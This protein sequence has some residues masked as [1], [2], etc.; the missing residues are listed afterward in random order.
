[1][2]VEITKIGERGQV[3]IPQSCRE[4]MGIQKG[5]KFIVLERGDMI[6]LK[7]LKSPTEEDID[8]MFDKERNWNN[9][10]GNGDTAIK[11]LD[12]IGGLK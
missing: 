12:I 4:D 3:V 5:D 1:M 8:K 10:Y 11:T 7:K 6:I 9:P 2:G